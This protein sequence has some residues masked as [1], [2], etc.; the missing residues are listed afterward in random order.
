[1]P[2]PT[3][4]FGCVF[5]FVGYDATV[6]QVTAFEEETDEPSSVVASFLFHDPSA[7]LGVV[8]CKTHKTLDQGIPFVDSWEA[9][10]TWNR[11]S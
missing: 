5:V 2:F 10:Q 8:V 6:S 11:T 7:I 4:V 1:M 9:L 3:T